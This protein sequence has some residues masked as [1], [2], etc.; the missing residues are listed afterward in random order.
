MKKLIIIILILVQSNLYSQFYNKLN[1]VFLTKATE[2]SVF[3]N[4][5]EYA[6]SWL[7][8]ATNKCFMGNLQTS[9]STS[10][11]SVFYG[12][13]LIPRGNCSNKLPESEVTFNFNGKVNKE[14]IKIP[15]TFHGTTNVDANPKKGKGYLQINSEKMFLEFPK[16]LLIAMLENSKIEANPE[17]LSQ[18]IITGIDYEINEN[19][20]IVN[21]KGKFNLPVKLNKERKVYQKIEQIELFI[22]KETI[23]IVLIDNDLI[24]GN[25]KILLTEIKVKK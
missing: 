8:I 14:I 18:F 2:E 4:D 13:D 19:N 7:Q 11:N 12:L 10:G 20:M 24:N 3:S 1:D 16:S 17:V 6:R 5:L 25:K 9:M 23:N 21:C 22:T 15:L